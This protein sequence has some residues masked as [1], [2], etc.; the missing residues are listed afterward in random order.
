MD[1]NKE[2]EYRVALSF[3]K[4]ATLNVVRHLLEI[5][6]SPEEFFLRET[7]DLASR[8]NLNDSSPVD[9]YLRDEALFRA[10]KEVEYMKKHN[11]RG[12]FFGEEGYPWRLE[13]IEDAPVF[14]YVLGETDLNIEYPLSIVG[15]RKCTAIGVEFTS[16]LVKEIGD[17]FPTAL[18]IS[19]LASG[20]DSSAHKAA[21][22]CNLK[23]VAVVAHG[24]N[25]IYPA[26][27]RDLARRIIKSGGALISEYPVGTTPF[28]GNFLERNRIVAGLSDSTVVIE[29]EIK[30]GAMSTASLAFN[31]NREVFAMP[32]RVSDQASSGCNHLIARNKAHLLSCAADIIEHTGWEPLGIKIEPGTRSMFPE[33]EGDAKR[34]Y[35]LLRF[36]GEAQQL[37]TIHHTLKIPMPTLLALLGE[38]EFDG[39]ILKIPGNRYEIS[40]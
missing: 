17:Y 11:I 38:L 33:L 21:L 6:L 20:I 23:T 27:N 35:D 16:R 4:G 13:E 40:V 34:I 15:T 29:S 26:I 1:Y 8:L 31:Y 22:E 9:R 30:G 32:G 18:I 3:M 24:L 25:M 7:S 2:L 14:L 19:G 10:G 36:A 5:G 12:L 39:I 28:R 37:D